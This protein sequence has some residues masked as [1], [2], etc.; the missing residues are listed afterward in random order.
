MGVGGRARSTP[1]HTAPLRT[2]HPCA[3]AHTP[4]RWGPGA[5]TPGRWG[6][7]AHTPGRWGPGAHTP[8]R[9]GPGAHTRTLRTPPRPWPLGPRRPHPNPAHTPTPLAAGAQAPTPAPCARQY[10]PVADNSR[11]T[12]AGQPLTVGRWRTPPGGQ[13]L[14]WQGAL[15]REGA[16][17]PWQCR[18]HHLAPRRRA[19]TVGAR[20]PRG[21]RARLPPHP[22][23]SIKVVGT[24][25]NPFWVSACQRVCSYSFL[26]CFVAP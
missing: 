24:C 23:A 18:C 3:R 7:G 21:T 15:R 17:A 16:H 14:D 25:G 10:A 11:A 19:Q 9:W 6:P 26:V 5:R 2:P 22:S 12:W 4:G 1:V 20:V 8:G 13:P